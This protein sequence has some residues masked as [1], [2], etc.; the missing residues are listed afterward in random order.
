MAS[1]AMTVEDSPGT[2]TIYR[3]GRP[4]LYADDHGVTVRN[5]ASRTRRFAWAEISCFAD[6]SRM[7]EGSYFWVLDIVR[8]TGR[9]VT[10]MAGPPTPETLAAIRQVAARHGIPADLTGI[11]VKKG[12]PAHR[13][14]YEDPGGREGLRY[15]DGRVW[16]PLLPPDI[17][18]PQAAGKGP[19]SWSALPM[20]EGRWTGAATRATQTAVI[21]VFAAALS[22]G[23][24]ALGLLAELGPDHAHVPVGTWL[25]AYAFAAVFALAA[26]GCWR[27]RK[28][29]L[30]VDEAANGSAGRGR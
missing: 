17:G 11:P 7:N 30:K 8:H 18:K 19:G 21:F 2:V 12:H 25:S 16:S 13:G 6:G 23:A 4:R 22:A 27:D 14:L 15:W 24:L 9:K 10:V 5:P 28:F 29:L 20:A 3:S 26:G 1:F